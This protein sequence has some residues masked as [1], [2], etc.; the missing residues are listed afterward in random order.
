MTVRVP[1][2]AAASA[3]GAVAGFAAGSVVLPAPVAG[4]V[5]SVAVV[6]AM[7][8]SVTMGLAA[9]VAVRLA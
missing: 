6:K 4:R 8:V 7:A 3:G 9:T 2:T 1:A 5:P